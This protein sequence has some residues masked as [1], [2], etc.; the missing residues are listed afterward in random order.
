MRRHP[1]NFMWSLPSN[2][3]TNTA[4]DMLSCLRVVT[5]TLPLT[6]IPK[7]GTSPELG[8]PSYQ[9]SPGM[10]FMYNKSLFTEFMIE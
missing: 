8:I 1:K 10:W 5:R 6:Q 4:R 7:G 3:H 2:L 9:G